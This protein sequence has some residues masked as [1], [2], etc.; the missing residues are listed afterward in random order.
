MHSIKFPLESAKICS[1][2]NIFIFWSGPPDFHENRVKIALK[3]IS[4]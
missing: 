1:F 2:L 4:L 3:S